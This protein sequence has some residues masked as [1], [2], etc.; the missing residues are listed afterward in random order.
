MMINFNSLAPPGRRL[1]GEITGEDI[2]EVRAELQITRA[3]LARM[4]G[5]H[6]SNISRLERNLARS[7]T[8]RDLV[9]LKGYADGLR[10]GRAEE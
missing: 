5:R 8:P 3:Q 1:I 2:A 6:V 9:Y 10:V 4:L 7:R